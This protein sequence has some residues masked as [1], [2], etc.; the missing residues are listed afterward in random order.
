MNMAIK[1]IKTD[2]IY[3]ISVIYEDESLRSYYKKFGFYTTILQ[4]EY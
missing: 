4:L 3:M 2:G 1:R